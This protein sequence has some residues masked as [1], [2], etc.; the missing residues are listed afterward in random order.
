[1]FVVH[2]LLKTLW[3]P[4][5]VEHGVYSP[6][7]FSLHS[8]HFPA[9]CVRASAEPQALGLDALARELVLFLCAAAAS[10]AAGARHEQALALLT[11]LLAAAKPE[12]FC[13]RSRK[14]SE[15][16]SSPSISRSVPT[17]AVRSKP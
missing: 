8:L 3:I 1:V 6:R 5:G 14:A 9:N 10:V 15:P 2:P 13:C 4:A 17:T 11:Q 16:G 7:A 12:S